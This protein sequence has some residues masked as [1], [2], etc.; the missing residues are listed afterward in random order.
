[1]KSVC[2]P[3]SGPVEIGDYLP[4]IEHPL[5]Q[6]LRRCRQ[7]GL[8]DL[9]FPG[10][11]HTRFE[12]AIGVLQ[13]A[14]FAA[15]LQRMNADDT[16]HLELFALLHDIGHGPFSHQIEPA[17]QKT[18][19]Q[20]GL[21]CLREMTPVIHAC[22]GDVTILMDMLDGK[23]PLGDWVSNRNLGADKL[24]Y[25]QRD[26]YHI[27]FVGTPDIDSL[28]RQTIRTPDGHLAL[29]EKFIEDG[30]RLQKFYSY[31]HQHGYLN[32]TALTAQRLLQRAVQEELLLCETPDETS[33]K[34]WSM[35]DEEL[36]QWL[37]HGK[38]PLARK[39]ARMLQNR[40]V[41]KT[42]LCIKPEGYSYVENTV[43][44]PIALQEWSRQRLS[45]CSTA[46]T[47]L[48]KLRT[49]EDTLAN[50]AG[51]Q[52]GSLVLAAM[53][54]FTKL[55]PKDLRIANGGQNDYWLFEKDKDH[56]ASLESDYL[57]TFA[58]RIAVPENQRERIAKAPE[59]IIQC[60]IRNTECGVRN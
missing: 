57:R 46:L 21:E 54:Y 42:A 59:A 27:G 13:R 22:G 44:K 16:R 7:L 1:M 32:K 35:T 37:R 26:A 8:N 23:N 33:E 36:M 3:C 14:R 11:Q 50:A 45:R 53:P 24:D 19:H 6:R 56:R 47:S 20:R 39:Y 41:F 30:K 10:A 28:Q 55:L 25:L 49:M 60:L 17:L 34:L 4:V 51:L 12:H 2:I 9:V 52:P 15:Q 58:L 31:L 43:D 48:T 18:H 40:T 29:K 5:F 38:A